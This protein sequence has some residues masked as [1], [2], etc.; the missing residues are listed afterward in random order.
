MQGNTASSVD[1]ISRAGPR[2]ILQRVAVLRPTVAA[3]PHVSLL[4][5]SRA[6]TNKFQSVPKDLVVAH[7]DQG[8]VYCGDR[9]DIE[10]FQP[11]AA[12]A[13]YVVVVL[14]LAIESLLSPRHFEFLDQ[15]QIGQE[16]QV[17]IYR[18]K[19]YV[20]ETFAHDFVYIHRCGVTTELP[21]LFK[22]DSSLIG[23]AQR[24]CRIQG[25]SFLV[26]V[27]NPDN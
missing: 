3:F 20:W 16:F 24:L 17:S 22:N 4:P 11:V 26:I 12:Y 18:A 21:H 1:T 15:P 2:H 13:P 19:T 6:E 9:S 5:A 10:V 23:H 27:T 14:D 8:P 7:A 25:A